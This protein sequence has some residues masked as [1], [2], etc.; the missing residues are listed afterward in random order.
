MLEISDDSDKG[1]NEEKLG[2]AVVG[3][4]SVEMK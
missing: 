3:V 2:D 4:V 1:T